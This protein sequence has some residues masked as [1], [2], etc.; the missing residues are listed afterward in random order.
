MKI[1][2]ETVL[3]HACRT[4]FGQEVKLSRDFLLSLQPSGAKSAFRRMAK[5]YHPDVH[6][7]LSSSQNKQQT[8]HFLELRRAYDTLIDFLENRRRADSV[9]HKNTCENGTP[10]PGVAQRWWSTGARNFKTKPTAIPSIPLE[11]GMFCFYLGKVSYQ[12]LIDALVWQRRQRPPLGA[13]ALL[14]GW[15]DE[16]DIMKINTSHHGG[17]RFGKKAIDL[18]YLSNSQV[19]SL[20]DSQSSQQSRLGQYFIDKGLLSESEAEEIDDRLRAH[21]RQV[22]LRVMKHSEQCFGKR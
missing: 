19:N 8:E 21:N 14:R 1:Y 4:L 6:T 11:F 16:S 18:G 3:L 12:E 22:N 20:L 13:L 9:N 7:G 5:A 10:S 2:S 17:R 15:L